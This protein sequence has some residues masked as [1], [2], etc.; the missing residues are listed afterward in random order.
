M[1]DDHLLE[2]YVIHLLEH[3]HVVRV[4]NIF[5]KWTNKSIPDSP[6]SHLVQGSDGRKMVESLCSNPES[7]QF[8]R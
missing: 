5:E 3:W 4:Q 7:S 1:M 8:H 2:H 6:V